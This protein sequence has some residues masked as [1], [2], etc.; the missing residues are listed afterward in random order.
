MEGK[1]QVLSRA[2]GNS[3]LSP[4]GDYAIPTENAIMPLERKSM[5]YFL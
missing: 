1:S 4:Y 2:L 5:H 3:L